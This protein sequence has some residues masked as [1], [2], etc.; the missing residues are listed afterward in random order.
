VFATH[1]H[2]TWFEQSPEQDFRS[3]ATWNPSSSAYGEEDLS[4]DTSF[5]K[6]A[7]LSEWLVNAGATKEPGKLDVVNVAANVA[8]VNASVAQRW[9]YGSKGVSYMSFNTPVGA[10][11][12]QQCGRA[13]LSDIHVSGEEGSK[14]V[15]GACDTGE[16]TPQ[17]L[18]LEFLLFDL[19][20]CVQPDS[21]IPRAPE[22]R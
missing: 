2:Y 1:Y 5:P 3:V 22:P 14:A 16:L 10:P 15:P 18:A 9:I 4:I 19:V 6:G 7:A 20:A 12:D 8:S 17:E 11:A 13:V 21:S